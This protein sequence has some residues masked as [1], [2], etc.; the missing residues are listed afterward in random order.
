MTNMAPIPQVPGENDGTAGN[1]R[2]ID[3][4]GDDRDLD[5]QPLDPDVNDDAVDSAAADEQAAREG[6]LPEGEDRDR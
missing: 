4:M 3:A 5:D 6:T 2:Y 1:D